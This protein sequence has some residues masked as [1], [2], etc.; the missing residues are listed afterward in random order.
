[1]LD[2]GLVGRVEHGFERRQVAVD[3]GEDGDSHGSGVVLDRSL[4]R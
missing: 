2:S 3:V 1:V 4:A